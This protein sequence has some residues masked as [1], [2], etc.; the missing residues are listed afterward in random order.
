MNLDKRKIFLLDGIG[1]LVSASFTGLVLPLFSQWIGLPLWSLYCLAMFPV[2][3][4]VYS[5]CCYWFINEIRPSLLKAII[6]A[7]LFYC[8]LSGAVILFFPSLTILGSLLL[9]A[10]ILIV[11]GVVAIE[12]IVYRKAFSV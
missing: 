10:E 5:L 2:S 7:N 1:A 12:I 4:G 8:V 11:L 9:T 6:I 3:Y